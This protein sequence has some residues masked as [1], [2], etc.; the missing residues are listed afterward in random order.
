MKEDSEIVK[1]LTENQK[2]FQELSEITGMNIKDLDDVQS[3]YSTLRAEEEFGLKL[4]K[5]TSAYYPEPLLSLTKLSYIYNVYT[6]EMKKL[7]GG[8][9]LTRM[10]NNWKDT[11]NNKPFSKINLYAGHDSTV[12]NVMSAF[13]VWKLI[14]PTY[15]IT[16]IFELYQD[17]NT[18]EYG[19]KTFL[20]TTDQI[21]PESLTVPGCEKYCPLSKLEELVSNM[22]V[23]NAGTEC[24]AAAEEFTEPPFK[25]P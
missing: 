10:V 17:I 2:L 9:V 11:A 13:K 15:A 18:M 6:D 5:W 12:V 24:S 7:K 8:P 25:G 3:L 14:L 16:G 19:V 1:T 20:K 4:P 22:I 21:I 23:T